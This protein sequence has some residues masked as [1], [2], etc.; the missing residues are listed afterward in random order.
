VLSVV[1]MERVTTVYSWGSVHMY[2]IG[3]GVW[4]AE[5]RSL[6]D[7]RGACLEGGIA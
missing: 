1:L 6:L 7:Y 3:V 2:V 5:M 4:Y